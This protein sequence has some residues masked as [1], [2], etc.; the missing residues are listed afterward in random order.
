MTM[1]QD[2][3]S[4]TASLEALKNRLFD[5]EKVSLHS[6]EKLQTHA[7]LI[8]DSATS[9]GTVRVVRCSNLPWTHHWFVLL[10]H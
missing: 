7:A 1:V 8:A 2:H 10:I 4:I 3:L 5:L 9:I 6:R